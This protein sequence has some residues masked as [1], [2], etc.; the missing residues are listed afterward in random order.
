M[1]YLEPDEITRLISAAESD[2][3]PKH[4]SDFIRLALNTGC[5]RGEL[6]KLEWSRVDLKRNLI[7]L[8]GSHTKT[9]RRRSVPLNSMALE[10]LSSR[11]RFR[12]KYCPDN[13]WVF[14]HKDGKRIQSVKKSFASA[15]RKA[16]ITNFRVHDLRH[17]CAA[18]LVSAGVPLPEVRDLLGHSTVRMT[19]RYAHLAPENVRAAVARLENMQSRFGHAKVVVEGEASSNSLKELVRGAGIEPA[20]PA[21]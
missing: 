15:C 5:R 14:A 13:P 4:L 12:E 3:R 10:V 19:E 20:T 6:L 8:D 2:R 9:G 17:T 18:W 1:R 16:G 7:H 11:A 21:V